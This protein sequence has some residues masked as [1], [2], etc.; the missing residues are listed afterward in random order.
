MVPEDT[1]RKTTIRYKSKEMVTRKEGTPKSTHLKNWNC[2][3][4]AG[5]QI[6]I[7]DYKFGFFYL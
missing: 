3:E 4:N 5:G 2:L 7:S 1:Y 6:L